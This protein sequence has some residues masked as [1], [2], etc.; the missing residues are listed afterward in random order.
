LAVS[1]SQS[2][3]IFVMA[4]QRTAAAE[5]RELFA[6]G[7]VWPTGFAY[8]GEIIG[9]AEE[10]DL[11]RNIEAPSFQPFDFRGFLAKRHVAWFGWRYDYA[12]GQLRDSE[13]IPPFL[14]P[15]RARAAAFA[16]VS[17]ESLQQ[18]LI[19]QYAPGAGIGWHRDKP[20]FGDVIAVSL[21]A[22]CTLRLRRRDENGWERASV[23]VQPRSAYVLRGKVR[24]DW[25]HSIPPV[26]ELRY[27]VTFRTLAAPEPR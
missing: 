23:Q 26:E 2:Y 5:Q 20:M 17:P 27:S 11:L 1:A 16:S 6:P 15:L 22:P 21:A 18:V 9:Y 12:G 24:W 4:R 13:P 14:L 7:P 19:N 3:L 8:Q 25:Q 10:A